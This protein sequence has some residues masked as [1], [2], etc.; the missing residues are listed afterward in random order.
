MS[1]SKFRKKVD[2]YPLVHAIM[3]FCFLWSDI[4]T[5]RYSNEQMA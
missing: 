1:I 3:D 2:Y 4:C 5:N